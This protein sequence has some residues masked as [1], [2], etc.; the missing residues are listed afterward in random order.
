MSAVREG[1]E[2]CWIGPGV[3]LLP[4]VLFRAELSQAVWTDDDS[5]DCFY[6]KAR[7]EEEASVFAEEIAR[8]LHSAIE[9]VE[10]TDSL[11]DEGGVYVVNYDERRAQAVLAFF[12]NPFVSSRSRRRRRRR[13]RRGI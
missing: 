4:A 10:E 2:Y 3:V 13:R 1:E 11:S 8:M 9:E 5:T 12:T 6:F 7:N